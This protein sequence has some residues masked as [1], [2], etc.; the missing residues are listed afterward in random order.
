MRKFSCEC[1]GCRT[2]SDCGIDNP[3]NRWES[4]DLVLKNNQDDNDEEE[5]MEA[6]ERILM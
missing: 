4:F 2:G 3:D 1:A 6:V 5:E